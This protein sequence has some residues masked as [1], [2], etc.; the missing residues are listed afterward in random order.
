MY[1]VRPVGQVPTARSEHGGDWVAMAE[2]LGFFK[3]VQIFFGEVR[4][5]LSKVEWPTQEQL[6]HYTIVV[7]SATAVVS[8]LIFLWDSV[9]SFGVERLF[10]LSG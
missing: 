9:L 5:E 3:R 7:L 2:K 1:L 4:T 8:C 6:K 10:G